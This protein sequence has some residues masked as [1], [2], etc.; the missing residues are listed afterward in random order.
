MNL[1]AGTSIRWSVPGNS[2]QGTFVLGA[3]IAP[4]AAFSMAGVVGG[5]V[6]AGRLCNARVL[7]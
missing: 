5:G 6:E 7:G 4:N 2:S 1:P 3:A